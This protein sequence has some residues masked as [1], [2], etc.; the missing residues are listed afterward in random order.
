MHS[1]RTSKID[2]KSSRGRAPEMTMGPNMGQTSTNTDRGSARHQADPTMAPPFG[3][4]TR[5]EELAEDIWTRVTRR[6]K[7]LPLL[8]PYA[9]DTSFDEDEDPALA[10]QCKKPIKSGKLWTASVILVSSVIVIISLHFPCNYQS[11]YYIY[12][13]MYKV[14]SPVN[15][16][17]SPFMCVNVSP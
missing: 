13:L 4:T 5:L 11:P 7:Q 14:P 6:M 1:K 3:D 2:L 10:R 8:N 12:R 17:S 15:M 9:T 16:C